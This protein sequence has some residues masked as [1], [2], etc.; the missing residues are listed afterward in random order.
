MRKPW[1]RGCPATDA[2]IWKARLELIRS[3]DVPKRVVEKLKL[4]EQARGRPSQPSLLRQLINLV[5]AREP[6]PR[7]SWKRTRLTR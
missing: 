4:D 1:C 5:L 3:Y 6:V 2:A 7:R